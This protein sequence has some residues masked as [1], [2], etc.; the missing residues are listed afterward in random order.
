LNTNGTRLSRA[1]LVAR[2]KP[3]YEKNLVN[4]YLKRAN[5]RK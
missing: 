1:I 3:V 5:R 2:K 4:A